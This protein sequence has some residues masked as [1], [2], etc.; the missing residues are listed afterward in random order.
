MTATPKCSNGVVLRLDGNW[1]W[2]TGNMGNASPRA[3]SYNT[4]YYA[5]GWTSY[6]TREVTS[7]SNDLTGR[8]MTITV[9]GV[10]PY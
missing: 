6:A 7:F 10:K 3:L 2:I 9:E 4:T 8:R 5:L 1:R